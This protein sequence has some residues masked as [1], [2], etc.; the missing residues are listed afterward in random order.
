MFNIKNSDIKSIKLCVL[1]N[2][3]NYFIFFF[4]LV[5]QKYTLITDF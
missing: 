5:I 1:Q 3:N 4:L 2:Y